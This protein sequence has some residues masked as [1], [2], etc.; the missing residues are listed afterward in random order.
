M[1]V[2]SGCHLSVA[3]EDTREH[4]KEGKEA[5]RSVQMIAILQRTKQMEFTF[6][7]SK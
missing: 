2:P 6:Y 4:L 3:M 1:N 5:T 7:I